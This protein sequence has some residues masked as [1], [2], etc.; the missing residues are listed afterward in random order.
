MLSLPQ[1]LQ[2]E[3]SEKGFVVYHYIS[4]EEL[5]QTVKRD[6]LEISAV[7]NIPLLVLSGIVGLIDFTLLFYIL[8]IA[9]FFIFLVILWKMFWRTQ[10]YVYISRVIFTEEK[11]LIGE[12]VLEYSEGWKKGSVLSKYEEEF[13]EY[14]TRPSQLKAVIEK[15]EKTFKKQLGDIFAS[16]KKIDLGRDSRVGAGILLAVYTYGVSLFVFYYLGIAFGYVFFSLFA[17]V[18]KGILFF[19]KKTELR[20]KFSVE[21]LEREISELIRIESVL[22]KKVER[23]SEG[24]ISDISGFVEEKFLGFYGKIQ[25][26]LLE[27]KKLEKII[28]DSQYKKFIN[29]QK[30]SHY[31]KKQYDKPVHVMIEMLEIY[32]QKIHHQKKDLEKMA[33]LPSAHSSEFSGNISQKILH[34]SHLEENAEKYVKK[35]NLLL[36]ADS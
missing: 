2:Q 19:S 17:L 13:D 26:I 15:K 8:P 29:F 14:L 18:L 24:E 36:V 23:F 20:M 3:I 7:I 34:F 11:I 10:K 35:M 4:F 9:Y 21:S 5:L 16:G 28:Q 1:N 6:Y 30:F 25:N 31:L 33:H 27:Q 22:R 12:N 32:R